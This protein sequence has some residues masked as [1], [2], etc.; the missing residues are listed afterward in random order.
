METTAPLRGTLPLAEVT[1]ESPRIARAF[2]RGTLTEFA[3]GADT[4][5]LAELVVSELVTNVYRYAP[6]PALIDVDYRSSRISIAVS[7]TWL[8]LGPVP[9]TEPLP[10]AFELHPSESG[11]G[12][13]LVDALAASL[14]EVPLPGGKMIAAILPVPGGEC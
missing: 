9:T 12:L 5:A 8:N 11:Y 6:G 3:I 2:V 4:I 13:I 14:I 7:D 10:S 1:A